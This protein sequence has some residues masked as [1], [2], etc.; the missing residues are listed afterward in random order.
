MNVYA[1]FSVTQA[2]LTA[3]LAVDRS[4]SGGLLRISALRAP[5][6]RQLL[7]RGYLEHGP[8]TG[9]DERTVR[10]THEGQLVLKLAFHAYKRL[11]TRS[12]RR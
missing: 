1:P 5:T 3:L 10:L 2:Q 9:D 11:A 4:Q 12:D 8:R 7:D 6:A